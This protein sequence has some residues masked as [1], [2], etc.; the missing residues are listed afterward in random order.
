MPKD[1]LITSVRNDAFARSLHRADI[2]T[3]APE[4]ALDEVLSTASDMYSLGCLI[5]AVHLKGEPPFKN[6]GNLGSVREH[7]GRPPSGIA[8]LDRDLQGMSHF[9]L[10]VCVAE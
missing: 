6:F 1:H 4:Y 7:A 10:S 3:A 2:A 5:H 8:R 9:Q